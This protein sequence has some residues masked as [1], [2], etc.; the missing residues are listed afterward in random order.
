MEG[1]ACGAGHQSGHSGWR[2][3]RPA[4]AQRRWQ[5]DHLGRAHGRC[6]ASHG[7]EGDDLRPRHVHRRGHHGGLQAARRVP[8]GGPDHRRYPGPRPSPVL[9]AHQGCARGRPCGDGGH[10]VAAPGPVLGRHPEGGHVQRRNEAETERGHCTHRPHAHAL[11]GRTLGSRGRGCQAPPLEGDQ[12]SCLGSDGGADHPLHGGGR[13]SL[14]SP[15]HPGQG[16]AAVPRH[17]DAPPQ[18]VRLRVPT[19]DLRRA[20]GPPCAREGPLFDG[21]GLCAGLRL[22]CLAAP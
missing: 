22:R 17:A 16:S 12:E 21:H 13:G 20:T 1:D 15:G 5:D 6:A 14:R 4:R 11:P 2:V 7:G 9:R 3:L 8:A 10:A 19:G 18:Q